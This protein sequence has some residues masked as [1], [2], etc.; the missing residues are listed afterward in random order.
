[1]PRASAPSQRRVRRW[2]FT[3]FS[4]GPFPVT[5][6]PDQVKYL[7]AGHESAPTTGSLHWQGYVE[8]RTSQRFSFVQ[9]VLGIGQS[10]CYPA[11]AGR[12]AN[13]EYCVKDGGDYIEL[14]AEAPA[15]TQGARTDLAQLRDDLA[16]ACRLDGAGAALRAALDKHPAAFFKYTNGIRAAIGLLD[17]AARTGP[18]Q[19]EIHVGPTGSGKTRQAFDRFPTLWRCPPATRGTQLWF[20]GY[21]GQECALFDDY[22]GNGIPLSMLLQILDR[23]PLRLQVK[24]SFTNWRPAFILITTNIPFTHW[25]G[26]G[27]AEQKKALQRRI[28][29]YIEYADDGSTSEPDAA[30]W[31]FPDLD[32]G[33]GQ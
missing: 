10:A 3:Y 31:H 26:D 14:G 17:T 11:E 12:Q 16:D 23:Y 21:D 33:F 25:Y 4:E 19:V 15:T 1:M 6:L 2:R 5:E 9:R 8:L 27:N 30:M 24:G 13:R 7:V 18:P 22:D 20:D 32:V 29:K 28:T